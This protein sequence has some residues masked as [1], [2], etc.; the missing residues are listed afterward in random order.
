MNRITIFILAIFSTLLTWAQSGKLF[1]T[2]NQLSS[3]LATQV[4]Q[5]TNGFI[6]ITTRNGLNVYDGYN[7]QVF[8][9]VNNGSHH[10]NTN[11]INCIAQD[12]DG[13]IL[14]GTNRGFLIYDGT[15]FNN[16]ELP[17]KDGKAVTTYVT[18]ILLLKNGDVLVGTSGYGIFVMKRGTRTCIP[19][20][21]TAN[22]ITYINKFLEDKKGRI[23]IITEEKK[24]YCLNK[25][26][27]L[28]THIAGTGGIKAQ[29]I[30][31]DR[32]GKLYLATKGQGV[33]QMTP[34]S[35]VFTKIDNIGVLPINTIYISRDNRL[36]IGC[37][38]EGISIYN[39]V[40]GITYSNPYFSNQT[41]LSKSKVESIIEDK[42]GNI[43]FSM[44]QKGVFMQTQGLYDFGYM[45]FRL[46]NHNLI[47]DNCV[48]SVFV[49]KD[50]N[51]WVGTDKDGIYKLGIDGKN[52]LGHY[53]TQ[54]TILSICQDLKGRI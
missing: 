15:Q 32:N 8:K 9:K 16:V 14:L 40:Q 45:G 22:K 46:G 47:G 1:N 35:S 2:D 31:E 3:N 18:H 28:S 26:G 38:G 29:D 6:W 23:W 43:W 5:D 51:L 24:L 44:F 50:K 33:Y 42:Q 21:A 37:N 11:Y 10:L 12:Q 20:K 41:N 54:A 52:I 27:F 19:L 48:T 36:F 13:Y 4:Y 25:K 7:F 17:D 53:M 34:G 49:D 30:K 39:P